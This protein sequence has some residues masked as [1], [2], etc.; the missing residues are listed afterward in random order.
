MRSRRKHT[1]HILRYKMIRGKK[2]NA[3]NGQWNNHFD[4]IQINCQQTW[5]NV[6]FIVWNN[7]ILA[8]EHQSSMGI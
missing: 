8:E 7:V 6:F 3:C 2:P 1:Q 4:I 5:N